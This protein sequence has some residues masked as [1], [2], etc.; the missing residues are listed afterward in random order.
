M[1]SPLRLTVAG[2]AACSD[3]VVNEAW[4]RVRAVF[5]VADAAMSR[6]R[7]DSELTRVNRRSPGAV[8]MSRLLVRALVAADR[9]VRITTGRFDPRIVDA[10]ERIGY[11]GVP[12]AASGV[13]QAA[14]GERSLRTSPARVLDRRG[15]AGPVALATPVDLGGIGKGLAL[16]WAARALDHFLESGPEISGY[17]LDAGG[18]VAAAGA[19]GGRDP[20][21]VGV[22]D[23]AGGDEPIA[24]IAI[25][26]RG[27]VATSSIRRLRW[28]HDGRA[29]HHLIDPRTGEP[30]G[31]GL[32]AVT[33]AA[34]DPAWAEVWSKA[35][36][37]EGRP[38]IAALARS[39]GLAAWWVAD[40]GEL[41]MTPAARLRT[42]WLA[43]EAGA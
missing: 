12:Q 25:R 29:V 16:R 5:D 28:T 27:A 42:A 23:P 39:R 8:P 34:A 22:E 1:A 2:A 32:V 38:G 24:V 40:S 15:R 10:L 33:V 14:S 19:P 4:A 9:A 35:L 11:A 13:P 31:D 18:D 30:G 43:T 37:L 41:E 36:F 26:D 7:D 21:Q 20:W 17:L 6:F 3:E